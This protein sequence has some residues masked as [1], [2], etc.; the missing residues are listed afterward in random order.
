MGGADD[1]GGDGTDGRASV[2]AGDHGV[3]DPASYAD[4]DFIRT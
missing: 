2:H 3:V 4:L 1:A